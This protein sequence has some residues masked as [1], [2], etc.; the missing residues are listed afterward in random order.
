MMLILNQKYNLFGPGL[1]VCNPPKVNLGEASA[2]ATPTATE[3]LTPAPTTPLAALAAAPPTGG[4]MFDQEILLRENALLKEQITELNAKVERMIKGLGAI[5]FNALDVVAKAKRIELDREKAEAAA[6]SEAEASKREAGSLSGAP[7][8]QSTPA[9]SAAAAPKEREASKPPPQS[10]PEHFL[11][12]AEAEEELRLC[13]L[14][15]SPAVE[16]SPASQPSPHVYRAKY[17]PLAKSTA[18]R[19]ES[20]PR[21][22]HGNA[23]EGDPQP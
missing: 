11:T 18:A 20:T 21:V 19:R 23:S 16:G 14:P 9:T 17:P 13:G 1:L 4:Q 5:D 6:K 22:L 2:P 7:P 15:S 8:Q 10:K 3:V 12:Q